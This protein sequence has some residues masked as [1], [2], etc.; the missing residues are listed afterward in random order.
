MISSRSLDDLHPKARDLCQQFI[1]ACAA[2]PEAIDILITSTYRDNDAQEALYEQGRSRPGTIVTY[3]KP[4]ESFHNYRLAFDFAPVVGGK[5]PWSDSALFT[6]CGQIAESVG[7]EWA[8]R[9]RG[10]MREMAH[11]Q[12]TGGLTLSDLQ[13]GKRPV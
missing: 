9:W 4:G 3:A 8:G 6:R 1:I 5:I 10:A 12:W 7:L 2:A 13:N 11:C